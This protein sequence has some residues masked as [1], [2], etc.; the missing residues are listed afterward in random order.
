M[1]V[2]DKYCDRAREVKEVGLQSLL[3][4]QLYEERCLEQG[5]EGVM[6]RDP[7]GLYKFGRSTMREQGLIQV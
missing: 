7:N 5:Y 4:L 6:L 3:C 1:D 2:L